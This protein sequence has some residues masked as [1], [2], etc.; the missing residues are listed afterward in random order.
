MLTPSYKVT[1]TS[2]ALQGYDPD[3]LKIPLLTLIVKYT[4]LK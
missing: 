1:L 2:E 4:E 3:L